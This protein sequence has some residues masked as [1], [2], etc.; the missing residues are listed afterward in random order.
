MI[1]AKQQVSRKSCGDGAENPSKRL[2]RELIPIGRKE[3]MLA[4]F[5][6]CAGKELTAQKIT[7]DR[8]DV[9][10]LTALIHRAD[11]AEDKKLEPRRECL[12]IRSCH[13]RHASDTHDPAEVG[14]P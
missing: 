13:T 6:P 14:Q 1:V 5:Q 7:K 8:C 3:K 9:G 2:A 11:L 12:H 10:R 4:E